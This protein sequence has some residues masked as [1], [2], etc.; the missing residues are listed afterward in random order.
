MADRLL[1]ESQE[2]PSFLCGV[3]VSR[4]TP[5]L[6]SSSPAPYRT[7]RLLV[8]LGAISLLIVS[9]LASLPASTEVFYWPVGAPRPS[10]LARI[11]YDPVSLQSDLVSF[12]PLTDISKEGLVRVGIYT[13]TPNNPKQWSGSLVSADSLISNEH[14]P[15]FRL[16]LGSADEI[17]HVS[18]A[19]SSTTATKSVAAGPNVELVS[20]TPGPQPRLNQPVIVG[21]D[22]Q[23]AE[24]VPEKTLL[25]K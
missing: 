5:L 13:T 4:S 24:E 7:M 25:Q 9:V 6:P 3:S 17:Y 11:A 16:H 2:I 15:T 23:Q 10:V 22:G 18:L 21:P 19:A 14:P 1:A 8:L 20:N 12:H